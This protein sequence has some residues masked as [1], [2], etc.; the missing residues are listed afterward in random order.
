LKKFIL[1]RDVTRHECFWLLGLM[2]KDMEV[3]EYIGDNFEICSPNGIACTLDPNGGLPFFELPK[4]SL[5]EIVD[6]EKL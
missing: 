4:D 5:T 3:Y 2:A 1:N 6:I